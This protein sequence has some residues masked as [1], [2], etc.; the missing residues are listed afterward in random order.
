MN[1]CGTKFM[2]ICDNALTMISIL[3]ISGLIIFGFFFVMVKTN[4]ENVNV[5]IVGSMGNNKSNAIFAKTL[6]YLYE[7]ANSFLT[8]RPTSVM[9]KTQLPPSGD[10]HDFL[11]L[12]PY[13]WPDSASPNGLP[14]ICDDARGT[15]PE[16]YAIP[17][18]TNMLDMIS[19]VKILSLAYHFSENDSYASKAAD[20]IRVWF[21][22]YDTKM[23]PNMQY[24]E[25][26]RG[27]NS[28][29]PHGIIGGKDFP[30]I[31][32]SIRL[33]EKSPSWTN[34]DEQ[35]I[36]R[37][38]SAYLDW[39]LN[40]TAAIKE[41]K[42]KNNHGTWYDVQAS[43]IALFVN[44]TDIAEK[45]LKKWMDKQIAIQILPDGRQP[46]ELKRPIAL[47]YSL[48]NLLGLFK[49]ANI[50]EN[51]GID[52]W[53]FKT[54]E[55]AGLQKALDYLVPYIS[56]KSSWPYK[57]DGPIDMHTVVKLLHEAA[58]HY[59]DN[60]LYKQAYGSMDR[61]YLIANI[62]NLANMGLDK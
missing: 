49:L 27:K 51:V 29:T 50:G 41:G 60:E 10:R 57:Q 28:G 37:W 43:A 62:D 33:I 15:N 17:D 7:Q 61:K 46:L 39:L 18:Y 2:S 54:H 19:R 1:H 38:F 32:E 48:F 55:G 59:P 58:I 53:N 11:D 31:L 36:K 20:L 42:S 25:L 24:S 23:N 14:Y 9:D 6:D 35:G 47:T 52:L 5:D 56:N 4:A 30:E 12:A 40:S 44:K 13:C 8:K 21:L 45:I 16:F 26:V 34:R 3:G 22:D